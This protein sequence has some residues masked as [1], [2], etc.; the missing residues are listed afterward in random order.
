[1]AAVI[2]LARAF[3]TGPKP[4]RT[5]QFIAFG[6]EE[7]GLMGSEAYLRAHPDAPAKIVA[8]VNYDLM[9]N[10]LGT[11]RWTAAGAG[12]WLTFLHAT[13]KQAQLEEPSAVGPGSDMT[14]F[15]ALEVPG[16]NFGQNGGNPGGHTQ[17]D[18]LEFSDSVG[19]EEGLLEGALVVKRLGFEPSLTFAHHFPPALLR[20]IRDRAARWGWGSRPESNRAPRWR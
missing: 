19:F 3:A 7:P 14:N 12:D 4:A 1:V 15:A 20:G 6:A 8:E 16:I 13:L 18:D 17:K 10:A 5:I 11:I 9:G 2:E